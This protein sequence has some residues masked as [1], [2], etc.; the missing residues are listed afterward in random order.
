LAVG[1][2]ASI[3]SYAFEEKEKK[4]LISLPIL[5]AVFYYAMP[6]TVFQQ[7]KDMKLDPAY[8]AFSISSL[9]LIFYAWKNIADKKTIL[10]IL[11]VTGLI[12]GFS[13]T[14]KATS[15]MLII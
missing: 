7:A 8:F 13:F 14:V 12:V 6:M 11:I 4:S 2:L 3:L 10:Q 15:L 1:F 5:L 9:A